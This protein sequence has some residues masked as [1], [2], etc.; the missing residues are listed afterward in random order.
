[1]EEDLQF[2]LKALKEGGLS[3]TFFASLI[4]DVNLFSRSFI[5]LL[6]S[7]TIKKTNKFTHS[8]A[9]YSINVQDCFRW[10]ENIIPQLSSVL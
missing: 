1:M 7:H 2:I 3:L 5:Q 10:M 4:Q 6:Y 8:L 9:K